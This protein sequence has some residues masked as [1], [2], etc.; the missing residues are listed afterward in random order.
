[1]S[2]STRC[3]Y[4]TNG[5]PDRDAYLNDVADRFGASPAAVRL[6]A[7]LMGPSEDFNGLITYIEDGFLFDLEDFEDE[8][9]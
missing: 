7:D 9:C 8:T 2:E 4:E 5:F 6:L 1:M 3:P